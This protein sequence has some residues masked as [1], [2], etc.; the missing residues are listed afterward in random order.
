MRQPRARSLRPEGRRPS[1]DPLALAS[2]APLR[3]HDPLLHAQF[4]PH[5]VLDGFVIDEYLQGGSP[6]GRA[7]ASLRAE[8]FV[9]RRDL[10]RRRA[11]RASQAAGVRV[12]YCVPVPPRGAALARGWSFNPRSPRR[13]VPR[14]TRA[15]MKAARNGEKV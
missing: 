8:I 9:G 10:A 15:P 5:R 4:R 14:S 13:P 12:G 3:H 11:L 6:D 7:R 1:R 2:R